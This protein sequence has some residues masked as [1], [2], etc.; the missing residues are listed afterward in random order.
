MS[1]GGKMVFSNLLYRKDTE[2]EFKSEL[3]APSGKCSKDG[4]GKMI[5]RQQWDVFYREEK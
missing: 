2:G 1:N 5:L 3:K 4:V